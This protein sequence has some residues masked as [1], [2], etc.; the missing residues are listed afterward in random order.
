VPQI[1]PSPFR[2]ENR[3]TDPGQAADQAPVPSSAPP[4]DETVFHHSA[5][6]P[7][8]PVD[9]SPPITPASVHIRPRAVLEP[10]PVE[11]SPASPPAIQITIGRVEIRAALPPPRQRVPSR[12][13]QPTSLEEYLRQRSSGGSA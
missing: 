10:V 3:L 8:A 6:R 12:G 7:P 2:S 13:A 4:E 11:R 9:R 1:E 5:P